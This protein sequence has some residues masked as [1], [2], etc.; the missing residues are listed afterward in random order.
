VIKRKILKMTRGE[1]GM[2]V[3]AC[4][5]IYSEVSSRPA[6]AKLAKPYLKNQNTNKGAGNM[7]Q[8]AE[9]SPCMCEPLGSIQYRRGKNVE[10]KE[11]GAQRMTA[12]I[13]PEECKPED[14]GEVVVRTERHC[15]PTIL[16]PRK[17][18]ISTNS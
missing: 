18:S 14:N 11:R 12:N 13:S 1:L 7:A 8:V 17:V 9:H 2:V 15:Q 4:T 6:Q 10:E 3:H 16:H 5:P